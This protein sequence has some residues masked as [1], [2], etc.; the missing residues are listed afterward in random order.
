MSRVGAATIA[1]ALVLG[2]YLGGAAQA[3]DGAPVPDDEIAELFGAFCHK[4]F[5]DEA[6]LDELARGRHAVAMKPEELA[7]FLHGDPGRG[8]FLH[9]P[10]A[11]YA[12]TIE[13]APYETC[14]VRR[15]TPAGLSKLR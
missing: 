2:L 6:P 14:V 11:L 1:A 8:W 13:T 9:T 10:A 5:P 7:S 12:I 3:A 15:M 4:A